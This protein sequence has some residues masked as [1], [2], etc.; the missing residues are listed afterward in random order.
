MCTKQVQT[1]MKMCVCV[2]IKIKLALYAEDA[3]II[4]SYME[5]WAVV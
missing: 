5:S 1:E 4:M 2:Q 3:F